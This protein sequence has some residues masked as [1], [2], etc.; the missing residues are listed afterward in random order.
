MSEPMTARRF[1]EIRESVPA[2]YPPPWTVEPD[3]DDGV[4]RGWLVGYDRSDVLPE[5]RDKCGLVARVPDYGEQLARFIAD[6]VTAVPQLLDEVERLRATPEP[7]SPS[8][9]V[10]AT[11]AGIRAWADLMGRAAHRIAMDAIGDPSTAASLLSRIGDLLIDELQGDHGIDN[12]PGRKCPSSKPDTFACPT[13]LDEGYVNEE[14]H[15]H[16]RW[17]I[18]LSL[19]WEQ[20]EP[21]AVRLARLVLE[22]GA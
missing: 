4:L 19:S 6:A 13:E 7:A 10:N 2:S 11:A 17:C 9:R 8:V 21:T 3:D 18:A 5:L 16:C 20:P 22:G 12:C 15:H 14:G 1:A